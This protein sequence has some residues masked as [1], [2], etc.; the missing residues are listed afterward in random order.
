MNKNNIQPLVSVIVNCFN[1]ETYLDKA[2][3]SILNQSY[4]NLEIIFWDNQST[5]SSAQIIKSYKDNRIRYYYAENFSKLYEARDMA[6]KK[7]SGEY[8]T[9]LDVD[10]WW[11]DNKIETQ[12]QYFNDDDVGIVCSNFKIF[13]QKDN[14]YSSY[15]AHNKT[16]KSGYVLSNLLKSYYVGLLTVMIKKDAYIEAGN[17]CDKNFHII[18]DFDLAIR[19]CKNKELKY[20]ND[21][22]ATYRSHS[23]SESKKNIFLQ[24]KELKA[25]YKKFSND[26]I[27]SNNSNFSYVLCFSF[28]LEALSYLLNNQRLK[29]ISCL[30]NLYGK[31]LY[32]ILFLLMIPTFIIHK[33]RS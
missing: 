14:N 33:I 32:K 12:I 17:Y 24:S 15:I 20:L 31:N 4:K 10:D 16:M 13:K 7:S 30:P 5:D 27:I 9:F 3:K 23:K 2:I 19:I 11:E 26:E 1:G 22:L 29:A 28:Y 18:G 25:W 6:I 21:P 8:L